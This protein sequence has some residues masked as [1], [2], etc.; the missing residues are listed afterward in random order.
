MNSS[1]LI[2]PGTSDYPSNEFHD[3]IV[4]EIGLKF[5]KSGQLLDSSQ[6]EISRFMI[7]WSDTISTPDSKRKKLWKRP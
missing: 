2:G 6:I 3:M 1:V 4:A 5:F 7:N